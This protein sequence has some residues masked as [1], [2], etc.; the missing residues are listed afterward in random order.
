MAIR[1]QVLD[2]PEVVDLVP[3]PSL[4]EPSAAQLGIH[5]RPVPFRIAAR[6]H[7]PTVHRGLLRSVLNKLHPT[8][9]YASL[10][11]LEGMQHLNARI[12]EARGARFWFHAL[13][14]CFITVAD[15]ELM[16]PTS[17]TKRLVNHARPHPRRDR[18]LRRRLDHGPTPRRGPEH[19]RP[20]RR[21]GWG[22]RASAGDTTP[23]R[24]TCPG[25]PTSN[26]DKTGQAGYRLPPLAHKRSGQPPGKAGHEA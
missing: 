7:C 8:T 24:L 9:I 5:E 17:L 25:V 23:D 18:G 21:V 4:A 2:T 10:T 3:S 12:G 26:L 19:R 13:H 22:G 16:L 6:T 15:R 20:D 14:N 11:H 1:P